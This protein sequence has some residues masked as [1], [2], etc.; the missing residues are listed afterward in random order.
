[1]NPEIKKKAAVRAVFTWSRKSKKRRWEK[2]NRLE[3]ALSRERRRNDT[4][5]AETKHWLFVQVCHKKATGKK[6]KGG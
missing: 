6:G 4:G 1:M 3:V 5:P 2:R